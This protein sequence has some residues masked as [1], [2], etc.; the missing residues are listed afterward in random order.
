MGNPWVQVKSTTTA[1]VLTGPVLDPNSPGDIYVGDST[2]YLWQVT[3]GGTVTQS[4]LLA[5]NTGGVVDAPLVDSTASTSKVYVFAGDSNDNSGNSQVFQFATGFASGNNPT[6]V[7]T[8]GS[9]ASTTKLYIG[10]FDNTHYT[11][12]GTT[13]NLYVCGYHS[14]GTTPR[15]FQVVM[16][17]TFNS[18]AVNTIDTPASGTATCSPVTEFLGNAHDWIFLSV[19]ANGQDTGCSG[20]C[21]YNY[22]VSTTPSAATAGLAAT[23][24]TSGIIIDNS[25]SSPTGASQIYFSTLSSGTCTTSTGTGGCA[26]QASQAAP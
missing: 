7:E 8:L 20:A 3:T 6:T 12:N 18:G 22:N 10:S 24:G 21:L 15:L 26:V 11:G 2:G 1:A 5:I 14:T 4:A 16:N 9:G 13:G 23:G 17:A 19:T 25:A